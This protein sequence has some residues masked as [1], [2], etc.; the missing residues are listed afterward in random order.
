MRIEYVNHGI[1]NRFDDHIEINKNLL[2][3]PEIY[4]KVLTHELSHSNEIFTVKDLLL[5]LNDS[6]INRLDLF[7]FMIKN[8]RSLS[9][10]LPITWSRK[11]GFIYDINQILIYSVIIILLSFTTYIA[12]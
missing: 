8:P 10:L 3:Y 1:G 6:G 5:D 4:K 2:N 9:Q 12:L 7:K 11:H